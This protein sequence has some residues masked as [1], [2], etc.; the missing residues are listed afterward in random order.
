MKHGDKVHWNEN[1]YICSGTIICNQC[2]TKGN[3]TEYWEI[4]VDP[5]S[6]KK[7]CKGIYEM[8]S[9]WVTRSQPLH[10]MQVVL[11]TAS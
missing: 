9:G 8:H 5:A 3:P 11:D 6:Y 1:G 4:N 2:D 7:A 10:N